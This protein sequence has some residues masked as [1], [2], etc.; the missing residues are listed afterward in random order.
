MTPHEQLNE[1]GEALLR[2][3]SELREFLKSSEHEPETKSLLS[4]VDV[5]ER[6]GRWLAY[7]QPISLQA[8]IPAA[9][10]AKRTIARH[11]AWLV[12]DAP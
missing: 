6:V 9:G 12:K 1:Q 8:G 5:V 11:S 4:D 10:S 7:T 2:I 3:A